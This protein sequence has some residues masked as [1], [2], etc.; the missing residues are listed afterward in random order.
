MLVIKRVR[1][2]QRGQVLVELALTAIIFIVMSLSTFDLARVL[3]RMHQ[4]T[5]IARE[6][7]RS[8]SITINATGVASAQIG[9]RMTA[10][11]TSLGITLPSGSF[12]IQG[13]VPDVNGNASFV[14]VT[15]QQTAAGAL[16]V[17]FVPGLGTLNM[18]P[19]VTMPAFV[20]M[21]AAA[22]VI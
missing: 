11:A 7:A 3:L 19:Q 12:T 1:S 8:A 15:V 13:L 14:R 2:C 9:T 4:L 5:Q 16:G 22:Q 10:I 6:G 18:S 20:T 17:I 21:P